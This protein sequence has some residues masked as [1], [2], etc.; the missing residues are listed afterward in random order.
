MRAAAAGLEGRAAHPAPPGAQTKQLRHPE[1]VAAAATVYAEG[2]KSPETINLNRDHLAARTILD[3]QAKLS[4]G[5][6][7]DTTI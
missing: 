5:E 7:E 2:T 3:G 4:L 6:A 1:R